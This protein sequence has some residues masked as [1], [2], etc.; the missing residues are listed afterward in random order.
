MKKHF[1]IYIASIFMVLCF[2]IMS[3]KVEAKYV[4]YY[5]D[6]MLRPEVNQKF[7]VL[8]DETSG[9]EIN[10]DNIHIQMTY[11]NNKATFVFYDSST[12]KTYSGLKTDNNSDYFFISNT[13]GENI[14][15]SDFSGTCPAILQRLRTKDG[16]LDYDILR[17]GTDKYNLFYKTP[18]EKTYFNK[19]S[20]FQNDEN[21]CFDRFANYGTIDNNGHVEFCDIV[22]VE[23]MPETIIENGGQGSNSHN[24]FN[25]NV[26]NY[27]NNDVLVNTNDLSPDLTLTIDKVNGTIS[28][29]DMSYKTDAKIKF[30]YNDINGKCPDVLYANI[31]ES[32]SSVFYLNRGDIHDLNDVNVYGLVKNFGY[33]DSDDVNDD[34]VCGLVGSKTFSYIKKGYGILRFL[35]PTL[36]IAFSIIDFVVVVISG[37]NDKMEKAKK[38]FVKRFVVG[39]IILFIPIILELLLRMAGILKSGENLSDITCKFT[40]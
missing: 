6:K 1:N 26:C 12:K 10:G 35:V 18:I 32:S 13:S 40:N 17:E 7:N 20:M 9:E 36:I 33:V 22:S 31:H 37:D 23:S 2:F 30:D 8:E 39:I 19:N 27:V 11:D 3:N 14:T 34:L 15:S 21:P 28:G 38:K 29:Y 25:N 5:E 24:D 16:G 4:C